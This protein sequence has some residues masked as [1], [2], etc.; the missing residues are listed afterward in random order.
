MSAI[1]PSLAP[2]RRKTVDSV[3]HYSLVRKLEEKFETYQAWDGQRNAMV[4][5]RF[6]RSE[7]AGDP[8]FH[9]RFEKSV[10]QL[11]LLHEPHIGEFYSLESDNGRYFVV[12]EFI[13][14]QTLKQ[15]VEREKFTYDAF[16][17]LA[18]QIARAIQSAHRAGII[19]GHFSAHNIVV[20]PRGQVKI[21]D[22]GVAGW[23]VRDSDTTLLTSRLAYLSP[24]QIDNNPPDAR[25]DFF[26][27]GIIFYEML[28]GELPFTGENGQEIRE[29]ILHDPIDLESE[30]GDLL[31]HDARLLLEKMLDHD[32]DE[33]IGDA[34]VLRATLDEMLA[35]HML[36]RRLPD[37]PPHHASPRTYIML[38]VLTALIII[39]WLVVA[40]LNK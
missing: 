40:G 8:E 6:V 17:H 13:E 5:I 31:P 28:T 19:H 22:F 1:L 25:S 24:E 11:E 32:P 10:K 20:T 35:Q 23:P 16:L 33:R 38:S 18:V 34:D 39:F 12:R 15:L 14:G 30:F 26:S 3:L 37:S 9:R 27:L 21:V 7:V 4:A 36:G 29:S 2:F